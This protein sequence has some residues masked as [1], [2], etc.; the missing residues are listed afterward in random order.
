MSDKGQAFSLRYNTVLAILRQRLGEML[1][2]PVDNRA[3]HRT[4]D[5]KCTV[6]RRA[7]LLRLQSVLYCKETV[8]LLGILIFTR[9]GVL[10]LS[11][12]YLLLE[13]RIFMEKYFLY[14]D[15]I[16]KRYKLITGFINTLI[17]SD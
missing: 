13:S 14:A 7:N 4:G 8:L 11:T 12:L 16:L 10:L 6:I 15:M 17:Y 3:F 5:L 2:L 9:L 1:Y